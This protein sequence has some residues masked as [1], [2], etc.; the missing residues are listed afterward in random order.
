MSSNDDV[1]TV[2]MNYSDHFGD[3]ETGYISP[4]WYSEEDTDD[5]F[6]DGYKQICAAISAFDDDD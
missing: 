6:C 4:H 5:S 2:K 3:D 1:G